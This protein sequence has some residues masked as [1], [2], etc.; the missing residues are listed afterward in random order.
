MKVARKGSIRI[1]REGDKVRILALVRHPM[2]TGLRVRQDTGEKI[3][4]HFIQTLEIR[5][6]GTPMVTAQ[7]GTAISKNPLF[8][9]TVRKIKAGDHVELL[10]QDNM[11]ESGTIETTAK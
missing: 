9:I 10:W 11:G 2:E 4:A 5:V 1:K 6:N 7:L 3:P 8:G